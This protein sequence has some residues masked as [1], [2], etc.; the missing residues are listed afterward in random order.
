[1][2]TGTVIE[3]LM[4]IVDQTCEQV[5]E[6]TQQERLAYWYAVSNRELAQLESGLAGVA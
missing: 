5:E 6:R 4:A 1:M 3:D 2:F